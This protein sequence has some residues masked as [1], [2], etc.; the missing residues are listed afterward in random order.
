MHKYKVLVPTG[1]YWYDTVIIK[2][3]ADFNSDSDKAL[4]LVAAECLKLNKGRIINVESLSIDEFASFNFDDS[5]YYVDL[6][7][8]GL[9]CYFQLVYGINWEEIYD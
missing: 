8:S 1:Y 7:S 9:G 4:A 3:L 5:Y 6:S 2:T